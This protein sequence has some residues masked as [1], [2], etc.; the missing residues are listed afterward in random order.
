MMQRVVGITVLVVLLLACAGYSPGGVN[1]WAATPAQENSSIN[2]R[3]GINLR[4]T[5]YLEKVQ[6]D[7]ASGISE[8]KL[9]PNGLQVLLAERH[10]SPIVTVMVVYH[11]GSR[12]EAV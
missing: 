1:A 5:D 7:L 6:S 3:P 2:S 8:Y 11:V 10:Q 12:N 9:K 4:Q